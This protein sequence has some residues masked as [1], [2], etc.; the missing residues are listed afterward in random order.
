MNGIIKLT[1]SRR[2]I[3]GLLRYAQGIPTIPVARSM[4]LGDVVEARQH[5]LSPPSWTAIFIRAYGIVCNRF[6]HLR[7]SWIA[8]PFP[9]LY[10]HPF[11]VCAVAVERQW[12][13]ESAVLCARIKKPE[14]AT[15]EEVQQDL[16]RFK[17]ADVRSISEFRL[18]LRFGRL[19]AW[20]QRLVMWERLDWSGVRRVKYIG[21]FGM[22]NYGML[23]AES[24]HPISPQTTVL[25][26]GPMQPG[27][28]LTV[29][30]VYDHR[31]L[32]GAYVARV[33][34][35]LEEVL[36]TVILAELRQVS[37]HHRRQG[38]RVG[39]TA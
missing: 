15:L 7:R 38:S 2:A 19:P 36:Q 39:L 30:L 14:E 16:Q 26:L 24:L 20:L 23:G 11:S 27:G 31:V 3:A 4:S 17:E 33:L 21:T 28:V 34:E 29:K 12:E 9:H 1:S 5:I 6:E 8:R 32:D 37:A 22:T 10:Q 18:A 35:H 13:G 25:T